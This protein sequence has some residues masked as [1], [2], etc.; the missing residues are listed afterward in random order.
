MGLDKCCKLS[1]GVQFLLGANYIV[2]IYSGLNKTKG[3]ESW[4]EKKNNLL[5]ES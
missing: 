1:T 4:K 5:F 2:G 3:K